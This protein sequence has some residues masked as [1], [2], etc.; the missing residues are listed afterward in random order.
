VPFNPRLE[1]T[2]LIVDKCKYMSSKMVPLWLVFRNA[3]PDG[4][5]IF[6]LF[7]A[8]DDLRQDI[9]SL[10]LIRVMDA[11]WLSQG[12]DMRV[13][14]YSV[15]A[16][17]VNDHGKGVG[18]LEIVLNAETTAGIQHDYGGGFIGA[19]RAHPIATYLKDNN[20][21]D[22]AYKSAVDNFLRSCAGY[23]VATYVLGI[24][25]R[26]NGNIMVTR[27]GRLFHIDFGHFLGN[28]KKKKIVG[29]TIEREKAAFVFTKAMRYV[30]G[31]ENA[32][33]FLQFKRFCFEAFHTLRRHADTLQFL[34]VLMISAGMPE[35]LH[36]RDI[37]YMRNKLALELND[38]EA[39]A[40]FEAEIRKSL[41]HFGRDLDNAA[42]I[43]IHG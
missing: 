15:L 27:D 6:I 20:K 8:G 14:P 17:G 33:P 1:A 39:E 7:K 26:H 31:G 37:E 21:D 43:I 29:V 13:K 11:I 40:R 38:A 18:M 16:T 23:C 19:F 24:G 25:D 22:K 9:L 28:F 30:M 41:S 42:H 2:T 36:E 35:L 32:P 4:P 34:F 5:P 3:D 10:Q 12:L